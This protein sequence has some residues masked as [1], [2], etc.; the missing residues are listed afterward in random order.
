MRQR[1]QSTFWSLVGALPCVAG[2]A[3][4]CSGVIGESTPGSN[5]TPGGVNRPGTTNPGQGQGELPPDG[6]PAGGLRRLTTV[7]YMNS[8]RDLLGDGLK[9][10]AELDSDL[11]TPDGVSFSNA[12]AFLVT[13][14]R[15]GVQRYED[16][17]RALADTV[18]ADAARTKALVGCTP[19]SAQDPCVSA[20]ITRFGRSALRHP[21]SDAE[22]ATYMGVVTAGEKELG[23][24]TE[25]LHYAVEAIL[26]SPQFIY[27]VEVGQPDPA[28]ARP[29]RVRFDNYEIATR[30]SYLLVDSTPDPALL[31][32]AARGDVATPEGI[33]QEVQRLF[34][35]PQA[36]TAMTRF[37]DELL[38]LDEVASLGKDPMVF[39]SFTPSVATAM[40][41]QIQQT[42]DGLLWTKK[43]DL[44]DL[45]TTRDTFINQDLAP[46]YGMSNV[47]G[48]SFVPATFAADG[49]RAG[50]LTMAGILSLEARRTRTSPTLRGLF[51]RDV[52]LCRPL[53]PPPPSVD[54][55]FAPTPAGAGPETMRVKLVRH[56]KDAVCAGCHSAMDPIG[57]AL[58]HFDG[59]GAYREK[60]GDLPLDVTGTLSGL[61]GPDVNFDGARALADA[62]RAEPLT[63][64]CAARHFAN[65][66]LGRDID[67]T[68][69]LEAL[70]T[71]FRSGGHRLLDLVVAVAA[72]DAFRFA[73]PPKEAP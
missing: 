18:F 7:Q 10:P 46:I 49:P 58:E 44:L 20:F 16:A 39:P 51:V 26:Q 52:L 59:V 27:R 13:T 63:E 29:G 50:L 19:A 72:N 57:L 73:D 45:L 34:A 14:S 47:S 56:R 68:L 66:A 1:E 4:G 54:P 70:I 61:D 65:H 28:A 23:S 11:V 55:N 53:P 41:D 38:R 69:A 43:G 3:L 31:D 21:L 64:A 40:R 32:A 24:A 67:Q 25:G 60:D 33:G 12:G 62:L 5:G 15:L 6:L 71:A 9:L 22:I 8:V 36:R 37:F 48:A 17:A 2:M 42:I 35:L 30:M